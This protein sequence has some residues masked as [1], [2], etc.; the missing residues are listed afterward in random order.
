MSEPVLA[1]A[2]NASSEAQVRSLLPGAGAHRVMVTSE[3]TLA[4]LSARLVEVR[5]LDDAD[6]MTLL[7]S[8]LRIARPGDD[9]IADDREAAERLARECGGLPLALQIAA[10]LLIADPTL[11]LAE[12]ADDLSAEHDR[13]GQLVYGDG[14]GP[15]SQSVA[16]AFELSYRKL[17][18]AAARLFR[19][20]PINPGPDISTDAAAALADLPPRRARAM[21][22][23]LA[24]AHLLEAVPGADLHWHL[25]DLLRLYAR[26]L[27]DTCADPDSREQACDRLLNHYLAT[28][29][30][31]DK[32]LNGL[33]GASASTEFTDREAALAWLDASRASLVAATQ[34]AAATGRDQ[35]AMRLSLVLAE[36]LDERRRFDDALI[37]GTVALDAA[38][39]LGDRRGEGAALN[40]L[41]LTFRRTRRASE[42]IAAHQTAAAIYQ[43]TGDR[44]REGAALNNLGLALRQMR[45]S[46]EAIIAHQNA[47]TIYHQTGDQRHE[48]GALSNLGIALQ[49]A[50]RSGEAITAHRTAATIYHQTGDQRREGMVLNNLGIALQEAGRLDEAIT[51][52]Q[53]AAACHAQ[54]GDQARESTARGNLAAAQARRGS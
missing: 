30:A 4:G 19:L 37:V 41:G 27:S 36:Y 5:V 46:G 32:Q 6:A 8:A 20:L 12:L 16:A 54:T 49:E 18:D 3:Q 44:D 47:A 23:G 45:R 39:R 14:T 7:D 33:P 10:D 15:G 35:V 38:V 34:M 50:D 52:F 2:D 25:H 21:L 28:A 53:E 31:V 51:A 1:I 17:N 43:Q 42:A 40:Y 26:R 24:Q 13:L 29:V 11:S 48:G 22:A 9:R